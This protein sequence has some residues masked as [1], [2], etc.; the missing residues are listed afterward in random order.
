MLASVGLQLSVFCFTPVRVRHFHENYSTVNNERL[1]KCIRRKIL[2]QIMKWMRK[3]CVF[4]SFFFISPSFVRLHTSEIIDRTAKQK[5]YPISG[6]S[7]TSCLSKRATEHKPK[8]K[9]RIVHFF[10]CFGSDALR[11]ATF[12]FFS[13]RCSNVVDTDAIP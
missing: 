3:S 4:S 10:F 2:L 9:H 8:T 7:S 13:I 1:W 12:F 11:F 5:G 6:K